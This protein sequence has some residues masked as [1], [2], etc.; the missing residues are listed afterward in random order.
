MAQRRPPRSSVDE[1]PENDPLRILYVTQHFPP[2]TGAAQGRA[3]DL[4]RLLTARGRDVTVLTGLP[5]Y[6]TGKIPEEYKGKLTFRETRDG[7]NVIRSYLVA[8]TKSSARVRIANYLS[9]MMSATA[10]GSVQ[11]R[12]DVIYATIPQIFVGLAGYMLSRRFRT[13]FV[14]EVRDLWVD[15]AEMLGELTN[16]KLLAAAR[17]LERFL[18]RSADELVVVTEGYK[19]HLTRSGLDPS[20]IHV[21]PNGIDPS[22]FVPSPKDNWVR[23]KYGLDGKFVVSYAGNLGLAQNLKTVLDAAALLHEDGD[24]HFLLIGEGA[25]R[26]ALMDQATNHRLENVTFVEQQSREDIQT[27]MSASDALLVILKNHPLFHMTIPSKLFDSMAMQRPILAGVDGEVRKIVEI[28]RSGL[29]FDSDSAVELV[30]RI[31]QMKND[32]AAC[33]EM[34]ENGRRAVTTKYNREILVNI[35]DS[36][37]RGEKTDVN[38][39]AG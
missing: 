38:R 21:V 28:A 36:V 31:G 8:D 30:R 17:R 29:Y 22:H 23:E 16:P 34:G 26:K 1:L 14:L 25:E 6:P 20:R 15:F 9:F 10:V 4:S 13:R 33:I 5:N 32:A 18:Y 2:E 3:F 19:E 39:V 24:V 37:L 11:H 35:L 27:F 12:P 7:I